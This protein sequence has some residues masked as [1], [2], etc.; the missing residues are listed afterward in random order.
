MI[1][2]EELFKIA[3]INKQF[4]EAYDRLLRYGEHSEEDISALK[5]VL[6]NSNEYSINQLRDSNNIAYTFVISLFASIGGG[7]VVVILQAIDSGTLLEQKDLLLYAAIAW[8]PLLFGFLYFMIGRYKLNRAQ[9]AN[10]LIGEFDAMGL[11]KKETHRMK[12]NDH[13]ADNGK[14]QV[15]REGESGGG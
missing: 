5:R 2:E 11:L 6:L 8:L 9:R 12:T 3:G 10:R 15:Q 7:L 14:S 13:R 4:W 1:D